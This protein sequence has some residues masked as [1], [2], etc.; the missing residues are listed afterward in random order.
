MTEMIDLRL[1]VTMRVSGDQFDQW[2]NA[3]PSVGLHCIRLRADDEN[4]LPRDAPPLLEG[5]DRVE[6]VLDYVR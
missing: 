3:L 1:T 2:S 6:E 5:T 4:V